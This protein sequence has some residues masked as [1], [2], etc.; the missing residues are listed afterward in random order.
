MK[1]A[2][3]LKNNYRQSAGG[4]FSYYD[5]LVKAIDAY[6][7]DENLEFCFVHFG[8]PFTHSFT[9]TVH[10]ISIDK[11]MSTN[12]KVL[13]AVS[14]LM[15]RLPVIK[16]LS[17]AERVRKIIKKRSD[18]NIELRIIAL[19]VDLLYYLTPDTYDLNFPFVATHWDIGHKSQYAFPEVAMNNTYRERE[20]YYTS[21]LPKAFAI[22]CESETGK[23]ELNHYTQ[24]NLNRIFKIPIFPGAVSENDLSKENIE[25]I[26]NKWG[27]KRKNYFFY[28][29]QFWAHKNHYNL[30]KAFKVFHSAHNNCKLVL[31]GSDKGNELYIK[32]I[33]RELELSDHVFIAG[34]VDNDTMYAFY[35]SAIALVMPTFLGPTNLPLLEAQQ[36]GCPVICSNLEGHFEQLGN[37]AIYFNP[38]NYREIAECMERIYEEYDGYAIPE[39]NPVFNIDEA[40]KAINQSFLEIYSVRRTFGVNFKQY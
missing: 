1:I 11:L 18:R 24:I 30:I 32:E 26:L 2:I 16:S 33:I 28:P 36:I 9:K 14:S 15:N 22:F 34:L 5:K 25:I 40:L 27:I 29:A 23:N 31:T 19:H 37:K 7:F 21:I 4:G 10:F 6:Q 35:K 17:S 20:Y 38:A 8:E 12:E 13:N 3:I 39:V